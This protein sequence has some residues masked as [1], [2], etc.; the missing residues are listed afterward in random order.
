[1]L[2]KPSFVKKLQER[3]VIAQAKAFDAD[4][5]TWLSSQDNE[6]KQHINEMVR[7]IM[8]LKRA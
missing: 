6:T 4:V 7:H 2:V 8:A 5:V 1:P 3:H